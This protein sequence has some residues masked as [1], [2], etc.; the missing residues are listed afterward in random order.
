[1]W[2][3]TVRGCPVTGGNPLTGAKLAFDNDIVPYPFVRIARIYLFD[4]SE[5]PPPAVVAKPGP[6]VGVQGLTVTFH[7]SVDPKPP[8]ARDVLPNTSGLVVWVELA[9][10]ITNSQS[11]WAIRDP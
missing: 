6:V 11:P 2:L 1:M 8:V 9:W 5:S 3:S 10:S 7:T 4:Q